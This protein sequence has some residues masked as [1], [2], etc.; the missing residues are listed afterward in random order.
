[1]RASC[2]HAINGYAHARAAVYLRPDPAENV[3][4]IFRVFMTPGTIDLIIRSELSD[5]I[6]SLETLEPPAARL[7]ILAFVLVHHFKESASFFHQDALGRAFALLRQY[8][9]IHDD[10]ACGKYSGLISAD[11]GSIP[12]VVMNPSAFRKERALR[13]DHNGLDQLPGA[14]CVGK[15]D[16]RSIVRTRRRSTLP[17]E[18]RNRYRYE[19]VL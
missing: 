12:V 15:R 17:Q 1:M 16:A 4:M 10:R 8:R 3:A 14:I 19:P 9:L 2:R 5:L 11:R 6:L 18:K 13:P 7:R